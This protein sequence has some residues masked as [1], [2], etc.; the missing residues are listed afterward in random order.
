MEKIYNFNHDCGSTIY[1]Y[2]EQALLFAN[3]HPSFKLRCEFNEVEFYITK[4]S[5][6]DSAIRDYE[7][8]IRKQEE[9]Y[10][11]SDKYKKFLEDQEEKR[12]KMNFEV[13][14]ILE[15]FKALTLP[16]NTKEE[17]K[18]AL[19]LL[20]EYQPYSDCSICD[21][22]DDSLIIKLLKAAGYKSGDHVGEE[23]ISVN[24]NV[25]FEY[26][27]GQAIS[28]MEFLALHPFIITAKE[29]WVEKFYNN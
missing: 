6:I 10:K 22:A 17:M 20:C 15:K 16:A 4:D 3:M 27:I 14:I 9:E 25:F 18:N 26:I 13:C 1:K 24:E 23:N 2:I 7:D 21:M 12:T 11:K 19:D 28:T 5:S 29:K 8:G